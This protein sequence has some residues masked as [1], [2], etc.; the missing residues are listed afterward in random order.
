MRLFFAL[1]L[2]FTAAFGAT[3]HAQRS[4]SIA[5]VVNSDVITFTDVY[6]RIDMII[7]SSGMPNKNEFR[8]K[9]L[10]DPISCP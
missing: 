7:K 8:Q 1:L 3:A 6:D 10:Y 4:D 2:T 9:L 5:A